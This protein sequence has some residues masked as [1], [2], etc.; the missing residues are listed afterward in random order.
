M[1]A[2]CFVVSFVPKRN[3][4]EKY[5]NEELNDL[6]SVSTIVRVVTSRKLLW[7]VPRTCSSGKETVNHTELLWKQLLEK[8]TGI[9]MA[10]YV[11]R[12]GGA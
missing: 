6:Y 10:K 5:I 1:K 9:E 8:A 12:V 7:T 3:V 2:A 4:R 11:S